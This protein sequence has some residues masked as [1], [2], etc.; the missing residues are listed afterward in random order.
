MR[1]DEAEL[2]HLGILAGDNLRSIADDFTLLT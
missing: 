2:A 1:L